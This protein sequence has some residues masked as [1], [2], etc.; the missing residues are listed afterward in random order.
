MIKD[1]PKKLYRYFRPE[2]FEDI[3]NNIFY[4]NTFQDIRTYDNANLIGDPDEGITINKAGNIVIS[5]EDKDKDKEKQQLT[6]IRHCF[7]I[8]INASFN[9]FNL[10]GG[11][12]QNT[13][14]NAYMLCFSLRRDDQHWNQS[15]GKSKCIEIFDITE[16]GQRIAGGIRAQG[17]S[18]GKTFKMGKCFYEDNIGYIDDLSLKTPHYFRKTPKHKHQDEYRLVFIPGNTR[19]KIEPIRVHIKVDDIIKFLN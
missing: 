16:L 12:S 14:P 1:P 10:Q 7:G 8:G 6:A 18:V 17:I 4:I 5:G 13:L 19:Q 9:T 15:D 11:I 2:H 3:R